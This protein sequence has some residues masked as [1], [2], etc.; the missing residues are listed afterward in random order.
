MASNSRSSKKLVLA[1][2]IAAVAAAIGA[3]SM[4]PANADIGGTG[5]PPPPPTTVTKTGLSETAAT[6]DAWAECQQ[7]GYTER[8]L[9]TRPD[10]PR[11]NPDGTVT[12][13]LYCYTP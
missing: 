9:D 1:G 8:R 3:G 10:N 12:V 7:A 5:K 2:V 11:T 6:A 13:T 4:L